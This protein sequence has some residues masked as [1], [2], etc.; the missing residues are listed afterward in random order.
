MVLV[1]LG[2]GFGDVGVLGLRRGVGFSIRQNF[3]ENGCLGGIFG[4]MRAFPKLVRFGVL[5][6]F[7]LAC[8]WVVSLLIF[9]LCI[10]DGLCDFDLSRC[11]G[12]V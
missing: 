5:I 4:L 7:L 9:R 12:V 6:L 11:L 8:V 10:F 2:G 1:T 3:G